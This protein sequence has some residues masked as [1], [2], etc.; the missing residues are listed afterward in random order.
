MQNRKQ[1]KKRTAMTS[2]LTVSSRCRSS[3]WLSCWQPAAKSDD[4]RR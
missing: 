3:S 1:T 4:L 2:F